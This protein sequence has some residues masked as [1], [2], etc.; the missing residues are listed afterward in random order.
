[1]PI[2]SRELIDSQLWDYATKREEAINREQAAERRVRRGGDPLR[3]LTGTIADMAAA[4]QQRIE[5]LLEVAELREKIINGDAATQDSNLIGLLGLVDNRLDRGSQTLSSTTTAQ[6][7][8]YNQQAIAASEELVT[9]RNAL[10]PRLSEDA[11]AGI[12]EI[13]TAERTPGGVA[14]NI[15]IFTNVMGED[16]APGPEQWAAAV[17]EIAGRLNIT[18]DAAQTLLM[19]SSSSTLRQQM[20]GMDEVQRR[21]A[22]QLTADFESAL[23]RRDEALEGVENSARYLSAEDREFMEGVMGLVGQ[24]QADP[25]AF[26]ATYGNTPEI[27]VL[28]NVERLAEES[29]DRVADQVPPEQQSNYY[30]QQELNWLR[31]NPEEASTLL[32]VPANT[33]PALMLRAVSQIKGDT[34]SWN[35]RQQSI[36]RD[37]QISLLK[38]GADRRG[39][40]WGERF[41]ATLRD[42]FR[43]QDP[44]WLPDG[45]I[46]A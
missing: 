9:M 35:A 45:T 17:T 38:R 11:Y 25:A 4:D 19:E 18:T 5:T 37:D 26:N 28:D 23:Q 13:I 36:Q 30:K 40:S 22:D 20:V 3:P 14:T 34:D 1:M 33:N 6:T 31:E 7:S 39:T 41:G 24:I 44:E 15:S 27:P 29:F 42:I 46:R 32:G 10:Q 2:A 8:A 21:R 12:N 43:N 16:V